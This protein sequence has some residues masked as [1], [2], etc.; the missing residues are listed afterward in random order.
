MAMFRACRSTCATNVLWRPASRAR[1]SCDQPRW[2]R[3]AIKLIA[4]VS[5]AEGDAALLETPELFTQNSLWVC[6]FYVTRF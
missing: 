3:S 2:C 1:V 5:L 6:S 4:S